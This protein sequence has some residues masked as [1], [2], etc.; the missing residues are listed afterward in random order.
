MLQSAA[1]VLDSPH[2]DGTS[3]LD[4]RHVNVSRSLSD[5]LDSVGGAVQCAGHDIL[6]LDGN[7]YTVMTTLNGELK[8]WYNAPLQSHSIEVGEH[9]VRRKRVLPYLRSPR[10]LELRFRN[11]PTASVTYREQRVSSSLSP[12]RRYWKRTIC[13]FA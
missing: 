10:G 3:P 1:S 5:V 8:A 11:S 4:I 6:G 13:D 2:S 7:D 12:S 9:C